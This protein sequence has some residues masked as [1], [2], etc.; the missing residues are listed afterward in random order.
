MFPDPDRLDL[1]RDAKDG[2]TFGRGAHYCIGSN[3]ARTQIRLIV[4]A[5]LEFMPPGARLR[6][7]RIRWTEKGVLS[8]LANLPVDFGDARR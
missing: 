4:E 7:D 6:E 2:L 8:Q 3:I 1:T 5:A